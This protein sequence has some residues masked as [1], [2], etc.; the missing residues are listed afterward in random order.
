MGKHPGDYPNAH[1][2]IPQ[3]MDPSKY[4]MFYA[5]APT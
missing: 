3:N 2:R 4:A 1:D 5:Y